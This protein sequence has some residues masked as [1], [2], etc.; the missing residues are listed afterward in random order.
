VKLT[1]KNIITE[2]I[3]KSPKLENAIF[4]FLKRKDVWRGRT[5]DEDK[6]SL[7]ASDDVEKTFGLDEWDAKFFTFKWLVNNGYDSIVRDGDDEIEYWVKSTD[8]KYQFL[9]DTGWWGKF[10]QPYKFIDV[11]EKGKGED[12]QK[13]IFV[14]S[15]YEFKPL[16]DNE[17]ISDAVFGDDDVEI[18]GWANYPLEEVWDSVDDKGLQSILDVLPSYTSEDN[19]FHNTPESFLD[20]VDPDT[21][22]IPMDRRT[23]NFI[24]DGDTSSLLYDLINESDEFDELKGDMVNLYNR[25]YN[26]AAH[27]ELFGVAMEELERFFGGTPKWVQVPGSDKNNELNM[28]EIP[29]K[30]EDY[31]DL[32]KEWMN[33]FSDFPEHSY[34]GYIYSWGEVLS[35]SGDELRFPD[36][37]Y[38]YPNHNIV[39][40]Y[41]NESLRDNLY[42][43]N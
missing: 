37:D 36:L 17:W 30:Q 3:R 19:L 1:F 22:S 26:D 5:E 33:T 13:F 27:S 43:G 15:Y 20:V 18:F 23:I 12:S 31:D 34:S 2:D 21:G 7:Q 8:D 6:S 39:G 9:K 29:I 16:F 4:K 14:D 11:V 35:E 32:Y 41:F 42:G 25:A 24:K 10:Y 38:F 28:L 40:D